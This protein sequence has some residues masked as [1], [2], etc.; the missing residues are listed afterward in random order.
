MAVLS[1]DPPSAPSSIKMMLLGLSGMG[2]SSA[3]IPLAIPG[4]RPEWS[5][6]RLFVLDFDGAG[7]FA[8]LARAIV[9]S[10]LGKKKISEDQAR[11]ALSNIDVESC[12][13]TTG[14]INGNLQVIG[15][16]KAWTSAMRALEKWEKQF[17]SKDVLVVD[18]LTYAATTAMVNYHMQLLGL[19]NKTLDALPHGR[20][21]IGPQDTVRKFLGHIGDLHC[22]AIITAHQEPQDIMMKTGEFIDK[23]DGTKEA[24][25]EAAATIMAPISIGTKGRV[26]LPAQIN[27]LLALSTNNAGERRIWT[28]EADGVEP[29][30]PFFARVKDSYPITDGMVEYFSL[31]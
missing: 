3:I 22:N 17:T 10:H 4:I 14:I 20:C 30:T 21:Y 19:L 24:R 6:R 26:Q 9:L 12:R 11:Q 2:K 1:L 31:A 25:E 15:Q 18:S 7:K 23:P 28:K 5:G 16:P 29:K 13:E 27:H 8:E